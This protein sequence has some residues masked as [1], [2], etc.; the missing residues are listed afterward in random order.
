[1]K[2]TYYLGESERN[3]ENS[4]KNVTNMEGLS[5]EERETTILELAALVIKHVILDEIRQADMM[6][7]ID[8]LATYRATEIIRQ[9]KRVTYKPNVEAFTC[10]I[11][12]DRLYIVRHKSVDAAIRYALSNIGNIQ[13]VYKDDIVVIGGCKDNEV[14]WGVSNQE[15]MHKLYIENWDTTDYEVV[16]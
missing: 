6:D 1:M 7:I 8:D 12:A 11:G 9:N 14:Y 5:K 4:L 2:K 13:I 3:R 15:E 16:F 10:E